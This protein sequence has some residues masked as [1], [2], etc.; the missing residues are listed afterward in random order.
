M[1][2]SESSLDLVLTM[3]CVIRVVTCFVVRVFARCDQAA[4][5]VAS[6][7]TA[8][9]L[10]KSFVVSAVLSRVEA[11]P[12]H[13]PID[14]LAVSTTSEA[15]TLLL[16]REAIHCRFPTPVRPTYCIDD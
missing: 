16:Q 15:L 4:E 12:A 14:P 7:A 9:A 2:F 8:T 3:P 5:V 13:L 1:H 10:F 11:T 6:T